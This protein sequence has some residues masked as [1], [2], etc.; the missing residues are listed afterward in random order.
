MV[1]RYFAEG[2]GAT[3]IRIGAVVAGLTLAFCL[4][5]WNYAVQLSPYI[6][7]TVFTG[8]IMWALLHWWENADAQD[9]WRWLFLVFLLFGFDFSVHRTN[10]LLMPGALIW[11]LQRK[12]RVL[13]K[14]AAWLSMIGGAALGLSFQMGIIFLAGR[15]PFLN[16]GDPSN[17]ERF[18]HYFSLRQYGGGFLV[19]FLPR[20][21]PLFSVQL[22][23]YT[24]IF[25]S[26]FAVP[27]RTI[28]GLL[29]AVLGFLGILGLFHRDWR[30]AGGLLVLFLLASI[31]GVLYFNV[32]ENYIRPVDRHFMPSLVIFA[33]WIG[34]GTALSLTKLSRLK[35]WVAKAGTI[36]ALL[37]MA[38]TPVGLLTN[39]WRQV[40][41]RR[42]FFA[43]DFGRNYLAGLPPNAILFTNGDNDTF[44]LWYMQ[45]IEGFRA[46]VDVINI[47]ILNAK[48]FLKQMA[49]SHS[50]VP[51]D[52]TYEQCER[53]RP[54]ILR[55]TILVLPVS[56][57]EKPVVDR[58]KTAREIRFTL[59]DSS[60][61]YLWMVNSQAIWRII[62]NNKWQR[63][64]CFGITLDFQTIEW[65]Q[66]YIR[67]DGLHYL[68][69][70]DRN[71]PID[72]DLLRRNMVQLGRYRSINDSSVRLYADSKVMA[73]NYVSVLMMLAKEQQK[74]G[75]RDGCRETSRFIKENVPLTRVGFDDNYRV[76]LNSLAM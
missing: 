14:P 17:L 42:C 9:S 45:K 55:D 39:N 15:Q 21:A 22:K 3:A 38:L 26:N 76:V 20:R 48:W 70:P 58:M 75:D 73:G 63:P 36:V 46:D 19:D 56:A 18:W 29:S 1:T 65:I 52:L 54:V 8:L 64:I 25:A 31:G 68:F 35:G 43:G 7:T 71:P 41:L 33:L 49:A 60:G 34:Y 28:V 13:S 23:Q 47:S 44:P 57:W 61:E 32:P 4:T 66:P 24:E 59:S 30:K 10:S 2:Q 72:P 6:L 50:T 27:S 40:D 5:I 69:L 62:K 53:S 74:S 16:F 51:L 37:A 11:I 67:L 12:P